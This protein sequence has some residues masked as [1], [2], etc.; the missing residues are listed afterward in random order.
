VRAGDPGGERAG[1]W[2]PYAFEVDRGGRVHVN[3]EYVGVMRS[4]DLPTI[5]SLGSSGRR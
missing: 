5:D 3:G 1:T 4:A 2:G